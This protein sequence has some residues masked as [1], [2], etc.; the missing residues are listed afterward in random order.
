[1]RG[2]S[3]ALRHWVATVGG[4]QR[5]ALLRRWLYYDSCV[6]QFDAPLTFREF[7]THE[8]LPLATVFREILLFLGQ[9]RDAL[10]FGAQAVNAYCETER[11]TH[12]IDV[13]S[14]E[15]AALA[16]AL[17]AHLADRFHIAV[18][19]REVIED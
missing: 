9:R 1:M 2:F 4:V 11:M 6:L 14:T 18:R 15:A 10:L 17:R 3:S 19:V 8:E 5:S 13:L 7:M 16:E 12:D